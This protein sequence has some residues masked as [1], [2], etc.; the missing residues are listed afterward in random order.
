[1]TFGRITR[2][3]LLA[4]IAVLVSAFI[5]FTGG[6]P[7]AAHPQS[8]TELP[9]CIAVGGSLIT[10]VGAI[11]QTTTM[12]PATGDL[13]G[14]AGGTL[15][16][17]PAVSPQGVIQLR[18][19]HHWVTES[20]DTILFSPTG[21]VETATPAGGGVYG[22]TT[23]PLHIAGG[24]GKFNGASGT[25]N[26][27]GALHLTFDATGQIAAGQTVFRYTGRVCFAAPDGQ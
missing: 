14:S 23:E 25:L 2:I 9:S 5:A 10:N 13:R 19:L 11:S 4:S 27:F 16:A 12:G 6:H 7:E 3:A 18:V 1:M 22:V 20:G 26:A 15:L 8:G 24:T 21:I 17:P